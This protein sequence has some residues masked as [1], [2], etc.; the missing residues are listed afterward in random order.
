[1]E[2]WSG[3]EANGGPRL[4]AQSAA[5]PLA[6][7]A[8]GGHGGHGGHGG[9]GGGD[10]GGWRGTLLCTGGR[11]QLQLWDLSSRALLASSEP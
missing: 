11:G 9:D 2:Q 6:L 10:G 1:M 3:A 4:S 7:A 8:G 5:L